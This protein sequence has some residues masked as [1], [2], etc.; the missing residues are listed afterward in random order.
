MNLSVVTKIT[1]QSS[2]E[3]IPSNFFPKSG[4]KLIY[5]PDLEPNVRV[6]D[7]VEL[8]GALDGLVFASQRAS[9]QKTIHELE[10][11]GHVSG[12][13]PLRIVVPFLEESTGLLRVGSRLKHSKFLK[14][15]VVEPVILHHSHPLTALIIRDLHENHFKHGAG[16]AQ[17]HAE[18]SR[19]YH[20]VSGV[21]LVRRILKQCVSCTRRRANPSTYTPKMA[22]LTDLRI[23]DPANITA[24]FTTCGIDLCGPFIT[25]QGRGKARLKRYIVIFACTVTRC[26]HLEVLNSMSAEDLVKGISRFLARRPRPKLMLSDNG[27]NF[28]RVEKDLATVWEAVDKAQLQEEFPSIQ[29]KFN[30]PYAP[31]QGGHYERLI[32]LLK[33][34]LYAV[35]PSQE[36]YDDDLQTFACCAEYIVNSRP[37]CRNPNSDGTSDIMLTPAHFLAQGLYGDLA[38]TISESLSMGDRWEMVQSLLDHFW[39]RLVAEY[40]PRLHETCK[41]SKVEKP[42]VLGEVVAFV[43]DKVRGRWPL[44]RIHQLIYGTK[45]DQV[46]NVILKTVDDK[47]IRRS[48]RVIIRLFDQANL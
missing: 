25:K 15:E 2:G 17:T 29:W 8:D 31:W 20:V 21:T 45:D 6:F 22:S 36:V 3:P 23:P 28:L 33:K 35:L 18:L 30:S 26:V 9:F 48:S 12:K 38:P 11:N 39:K 7:P 41:W 16:T 44:A 40:L 5:S 37:L 27:S 32:A 13:N 1:H 46:R 42:L 4:E 14:Q 34:A 24:P 19:K 47:E 10:E 43:D